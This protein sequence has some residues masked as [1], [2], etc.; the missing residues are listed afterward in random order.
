MVLAHG[1]V[2]RRAHAVIARLGTTEE[3]PEIV[4]LVS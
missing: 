4:A 1:A 3:K 2:E